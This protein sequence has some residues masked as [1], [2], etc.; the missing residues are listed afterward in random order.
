MV[1]RLPIDPYNRLW[2]AEG[3]STTYL[4][5][6]S[7]LVLLD[8][9]QTVVNNLSDITIPTV[10]LQT[11]LTTSGN[12]T[13]QGMFG[14]PDP[15]ISSPLTNWIFAYI[16]FYFAELDSNATATSREFY[17]QLPYLSDQYINPLNDT[18]TS[19][20]FV[21]SRSIQ[22]TDFPSW[23]PIPLYRGQNST[24]GPS[25]NALEFLEVTW[26]SNL[27]TIDRDGTY[28]NV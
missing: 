18:N 5:A 10:M 8:A 27:K 9:T 2:S 28:S 6:T 15:F 11:A 22:Y 23:W 24:L 21:A 4:S 17:I 13:I 12:M 1:Y 20:P 19:Q 26:T 25:L 7:P 3:L 16:V 14:T